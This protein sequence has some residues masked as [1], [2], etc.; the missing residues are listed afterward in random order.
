[1]SPT[2]IHQ[3]LLRQPFMPF[4]LYL[5]DGR[6]FDVKHPDAAFPTK[7]A[8]HIVSGHDPA[9]GEVTRRE[10]VGMLHVTGITQHR[11]LAA[12]AAD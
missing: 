12:L 11:T 7:N 6:T 1:M 9:T 10:V 2:E 4:R 3:V 8:I 5:S